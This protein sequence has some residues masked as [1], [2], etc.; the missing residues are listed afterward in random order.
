[1][2]VSWILNYILKE[3][4][5]AFLNANS[6]KELWDEIHQHFDEC[7]GPM[8]YQLQKEIKNLKQRNNTVA[9][10]FTKVKKLWDE[11]NSLMPIPVCSCGTGKILVEIEM[12]N[13]LIQF[14]V[15]LNDSYDHVQNQN[16]TNGA[17]A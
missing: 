8:I 17:T 1:M 3:M 2:V 4:V 11:F 10:Y 7:N 13:K 5:E 15:G 6:A 16:F 14:L 12:H 9:I